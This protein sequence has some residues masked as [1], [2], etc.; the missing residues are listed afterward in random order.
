MQRNVVVVGGSLAGLRT[1]ET[2]RA[3]GHDGRISWVGEEPSLPY[4]RPPLSKEFLRAEVIESDLELRRGG[5]ESLA[6]D[7]YFGRRARAL[8]AVEREVE[9]EDGTRLHFDSLVVATGA[10][11]RVLPQVGNLAGV[12]A[13]RTLDDARAIRAALSA[14]PR[15]GVI[16]GGF[17]GSEVA[18]SCRALGLSVSLVEPAGGLCVGALGPELGARLAGLHLDHGVDVRCGVSVESLEGARRVERIRLSDG[19][20]I[21][22]DLV[23]VG[24]GTLANT[25]WL[26]ASP[27]ELADGVVCD[28]TCAT[29][30]PGIYAAG[31]VASVYHP[32]YGRYLRI[33]HWTHAVDQAV[34]AARALLGTDDP[35]P[36]ASIPLVWSEQ[37]GVR[38]EIVGLHDPEARTQLV[39]GRLSS[40][41]F[42]VAS[43]RKGRIVGAVTWDEPRRALQL[44]Q[45]AA[46]GARLSDL[47]D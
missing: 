7:M 28:A 34:T 3:L 41:R 40:Q 42:A 38:I 21:A 17:I 24:I 47:P 15:V 20:V 46:R 13:L 23:V 18:A 36:L 4:E 19:S 31:D 25:R 33:G 12:Y 26:E 44:R 5:Y 29:R 37:Y 14:Q 22:A 9:L 10:R 2:L 16:G 32:V 8:R 39:G 43:I 45:L 6:V 30:V 11:A 27:L 1:I 35:T